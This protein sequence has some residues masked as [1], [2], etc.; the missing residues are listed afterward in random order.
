MSY[1]VSV[2]VARAHDVP[3]CALCSCLAGN[4]ASSIHPH[5]K[6]QHHRDADTNTTGNGNGHGTTATSHLRKAER[7][8]QQGLVAA[9]GGVG[10]AALPGSP[11]TGPGEAG[12]GIDAR[13]GGDD[14][15]LGAVA[16]QRVAHA[17]IEEDFIA[18]DRDADT[19][20]DIRCVSCVSGLVC[21]ARA[22]THWLQSGPGWVP[23]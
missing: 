4:G 23:S 21:D 11:V 1:R 5:H 15:S 3:T 10:G 18:A 8:R 13:D 7:L 19:S 16:R 14:G 2:E 12:D 20:G 17:S 9:G 6:P 22:I